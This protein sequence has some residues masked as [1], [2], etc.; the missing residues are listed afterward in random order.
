MPKKHYCTVYRR[1]HGKTLPKIP[2]AIHLYP[3]LL[4]EPV[5]HLQDPHSQ[6]LL[7]E[8]CQKRMQEEE[9]PLAQAAGLLHDC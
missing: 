7:G 6:K 5:G 2:P 8:W 3:A 1:V 9:V 4:N